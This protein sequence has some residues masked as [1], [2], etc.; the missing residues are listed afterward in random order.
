[1][2]DVTEQVAL[3]NKEP[4]FTTDEDVLLITEACQFESN[5]KH[6]E[7]AERLR[8]WQTVRVVFEQHGFK[9]RGPEQFKR[10]DQSPYYKYV[11]R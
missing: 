2:C 4:P 6:R 8:F 5:I 1:M 9:P 7:K 11:E 10:Q 3:Q